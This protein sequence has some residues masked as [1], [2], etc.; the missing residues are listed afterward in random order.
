[1]SA[2][3]WEVLVKKGTHQQNA[4]VE[5]LTNYAGDLLDMVRD[6]FPTYTLHNR[7]HA[8]NVISNM[9]NLLGNRTEDLT[10]LEAAM[11]ILAA[12][13]HDSGMAFAEEERN[14]IT[15]SAE[16]QTYLRTHPSEYLRYKRNDETINSEVIEGYCRWVHADR[17]KTILASLPEEKLRWGSVPIAHHLGELCRSHNLATTSLKTDIFDHLF[18]KQCDLRL[19]AIILRL[20][21]ILDFDNS[22][23]PEAVYRYMGI[24]RAHTERLRRSEVEWRKHLKSDGFVFPTAKAA[25]YELGFIAAPDHP[26]VQHDVLEFLEVIETELA[27]CK[28]L[29]NYCTD[30]WR[31]LP[32]PGSIDR[33][34]I[35]SDGF[36]YGDF[37]FKLDKDAI[38]DLFMGENLYPNSDVF[39]REL[40]QNSIDAVRARCRLEGVEVASSGYAINVSEWKDDEGYQWVRVDDEGCGMSLEVIENFLLRVG[41]SYYSTAGFK[42]AL[43][44]STT[45]T[46]SPMVSIGKFGVGLLSAFLVADRIELSTRSATEG[47]TR[48]ESIRLSF[49]QKTDFLVVQ[50][51]S[52]QSV[53]SSMPSHSHSIEHGY[54]PPGRPGTSIALRIDQNKKTERVDVKRLCGHFLL[55]TPVK[56]SLDNEQVTLSD[57]NGENSTSHQLDWGPKLKQ[58]A[59]EVAGALKQVTLNVRKIDLSAARARDEIDGA[60]YLVTVDASALKSVMST[61]SVEKL[62]GVAGIS[63]DYKSP[64]DDEEDEKQLDVNDPTSPL[65]NGP[66]VKLSFYDG[67]T[68]HISLKLYDNQAYEYVERIDPYA[69]DAHERFAAIGKYDSDDEFEFKARVSFSEVGL[70][71]PYTASDD[72]EDDD[73]DDDDDY[74]DDY[75]YD[76]GLHPDDIFGDPMYWDR[77]WLDSGG[78]YVSSL[79]HNGIRLPIDFLD[80]DEEWLAVSSKDTHHYTTGNV[81]ASIWLSDSL[82]PDLNVARDHVRALPYAVVSALQLTLRRALLSASETRAADSILRNNSVL[83]NLQRLSGE[84]TLAEIGDDPLITS[85]SGW[86]SEKLFVMEGCAQRVSVNDLSL[87]LTTQHPV[88]IIPRTGHF[89]DITA[90]ALMHLNFRFL[91]LGWGRYEILEASNADSADARLL[92]YPPVSF[93]NYREGPALLKRVRSSYQETWDLPNLAHPLVDWYLSISPSLRN[94]NVSAD[95]DLSSFLLGYGPKLRQQFPDFRSAVRRANKLLDGIGPKYSGELNKDMLGTKE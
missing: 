92:Q 50:T 13:F 82:R 57:P 16:F 91:S 56:V 93:A 2:T 75:D 47:G 1:M 31:D 51:E 4:D 25:D 28:R 43:M 94:L 62:P 3:L 77:G 73:D 60:G 34:D 95:R 81:L 7:V 5:W 44:Q 15:N 35:I 20:A 19:C 78:T 8:K 90:L 10:A 52:K 84:V 74:D 79:S 42:A 69:Q 49:P 67:D 54:R 32:L 86:V 29:I 64:W 48:A 41:A 76:H 17:V 22:R 58:L 21:D 38:L 45:D 87:A 11:L 33:S 18:I 66:F 27:A 88:V 9:E 71:L 23:S 89:T 68:A 39:L 53:P 59:P 26:V 83:N 6:T 85:D 65:R 36:T 63:F 72:D 12:Y 61:L 30:R 55:N 14:N 40:L 24:R 46:S 80:S 37:R 70:L